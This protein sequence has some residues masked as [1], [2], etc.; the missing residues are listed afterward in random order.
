MSLEEVWDSELG[1]WVYKHSDDESDDSNDW[2]I[3]LCIGEP[4]PEYTKE[5]LERM[6]VSYSVLEARTHGKENK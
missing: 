2:K 5:D 4:L 1:D 3:P 6:S